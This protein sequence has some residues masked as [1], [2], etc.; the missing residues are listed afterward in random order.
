MYDRTFVLYNAKILEKLKGIWIMEGISEMKRKN[1]GKR[2]AAATMATLMG[3]SQSGVI[4]FA[5][6]GTTNGGTVGS[7]ILITE[8]V[9]NTDNLNGGDAYEYYELTNITDSSVDMSKYDIVYDNGSTKTTWTPDINNFKEIPGKSSVLVWIKNAGNQD[10]KKADFCNYYKIS[11]DSAI[12]E[13]SC[14][15][16]SNSGSRTL[17]IEDKEGK[18]LTTAVYNASDSANKKIDVDEAINFVYDSDTA[19]AVYDKEPSPLKVQSEDINVVYKPQE[20]AG[21]ASG[22]D[23]KG[24]EGPNTGNSNEG[25]GQNTGESGDQ[26]GDAG[27]D[28]GKTQDENVDTTKAPALVITEVLPDSSNINGADA[29]EYIEIYNN[30]DREINLKDYQLCY[31]YPDTGVSVTW[32]ETDEDKKLQAGQTLVFW[33]KNGYNDSLTRDDFN[34]KFD[35][36]LTDDQLI[37]IQCGG[38]ANGSRR[39]L[40][41]C[42]KVKDVIDTVMYNDGGV[43]NTNPD[44]SIT[45][46]NKY[47]D[48]VFTTVMTSDKAKTTPGTVTDS[49]KPAYQA[50]IT[51]PSAEPVLTD[52]TAD[53]FDNTTDGLSFGVEAVPTGASVKSVKLYLKYNDRKDYVTYSLERKADGGNSFEKTLNNVDLL[54][55]HSFTYYFEVSDGFSTVKTKENTIYNKDAA[56]DVSLN[57]KDGDVLS[58]SQQLIAHSDQLLIDGKKVEDTKASINGYGKIA[59]EATD[60]DVFFKNAVAVDG[61]VVGIFNDGTYSDVKTYVYDI[62][63]EKFDASTGKI[64]VEFHAGNKANALE[65]NIENNDDFTLRNIRLVLPNGKTLIPESYKAKKGLGVVEHDNM[66]NVSLVDVKIPTQETD[67]AMGD[68]TSKYEILYATFQLDESDFDAVR[69][70]WDTTKTADGSHVISNGTDNVTVTV[71]NTAPVITTNMQDGREYHNGT[72]EVTAKDAISSKVNT[73]VLLDQKEIQVPYDFKALA[74]NEGEHVLHITSSDSVG[75]VSEKEIKFTTPK[76]SAEIDE[77]V[78]PVNGATVTQNPILSITPSDASGDD[79]TVTFKKGDHY[80]LTDSNI[81]MESGISDRNGSAEKIF[82]ENN[83]NGFPFDSFTIKPEDSVDDNT[84]MSIKWTGK[85]NNA[86]TFLYVFNTESNSWEKLDAIQTVDGENMTLTGEVALKNHLLSG[87]VHAIVQNGEGCTPKQF[88]ATDNSKIIENS[89]NAGATGKEIAEKNLFSV[90]KTLDNSKSVNVTPDNTPTYNEND[91][92]RDSY[93]FTFVVESDTQYYNEDYEGNPDKS[94]DGKYQHQLNMH[95][96][97]LANRER[98]NIQYLFHDGDIIDDEPNDKEWEQADKAYSMLDE[99]NLPYGLLAG[100]HDVGHLLGSYANFSKYFGESRYA[101]SA[102]YG[103][104]YKDNRGHYDLISVGGID[105]IVLYMGW[106]IGDDEIAWMNNVLSQYPERKAILNFHEYLLASGGL[107]EEPQRV[108]DEVVA[109]NDNVC[110][111]LSGHYHNAKTKVDTFTKSDGSTRKVYNLL[112]DYQGLI[113]G[114]A[115]YMR[116]MHFDLKD[117]KIIVRTYTPS[118][119]GTDYNDYGDYDAKPS[120]NPN[121]GNEFCIEEANL[122]DAE[123]FEIPFAD[124]GIESKVKTLE[125]KNLDVNVYNN[126]VIGTVTDVKSGSSASV[127]FKDAVNG[128]NGWYAEVTD[129]YGGFSRSNVSY[130]NVNITSGQKTDDSGIE[131][132]NSS[133]ITESHEGQGAPKIEFADTDKLS[134]ALLTSDELKRVKNGEKLLVSL[135]TKLADSGLTKE[136]QSVA[137]DLLKDNTVG[138]ILDITLSKQIGTDA[139]AA[140]SK[141]NEPIKL[142]IKIP[143]NLKNTDSAKKRV[144]QVIR[145]H[146]GKADLLDGDYQNGVFTILTDSFSKYIL[147]YHDVEISNN[148]SNEGSM[149]GTTE[150]NNITETSNPSGVEDKDTG[151]SNTTG[152]VAKQDD[153]KVSSKNEKTPLTGDFSPVGLF[154]MMFSAACATLITFL[155]KRIRR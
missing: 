89:L 28:L 77:N 68:G 27:T 142:D 118:Y 43:D 153:V 145:F 102:W 124:L 79:M 39:G 140:V 135:D 136:E 24:E 125:T 63:A 64:T 54:N 119:G 44:K 128:A 37:Q 2:I 94:V 26:K 22:S 4:V 45:Y 66:D 46:Q 152:N 113:E 82:E 38:M 143:D 59:F 13:I 81:T 98:M 10:S 11:E 80:E 155:K 141:T 86:K 19:K 138:L 110:M 97:I 154:I 70:N 129:A 25:S 139:K 55:K 76:E 7:P 99:A 23:S 56:K 91:T 104:S 137:S 150:D 131:T 40:S 95:N 114:G 144:Y 100:N 18:V 41:I 92:P 52:K 48:G 121:P 1:K 60:T 126:Q 3:L 31:L 58:S 14:G 69:V 148:E 42:S 72:I 88:E 33:V 30:S 130:V 74:M 20:E 62:G 83:G 67:I 53:A 6:E 105:F 101:D 151:A 107:G 120:E 21:N 75:N 8:V 50:S 127:E 132:D 47:A 51:V 12:V 71:D 65:H 109:K 146:D 32:W 9:P 49:E 122:N 147:V 78:S 108:H 96:W 5:Q 35:T 84:V 116:L 73:T 123:S 111:V 61:D 16:L 90:S 15:G 17:T 115:G 106:G 57:V 93:D 133:V 87:S 85:S 134:S 34:K 29:Y 117:K 103:G 149:S 36:S 112:F